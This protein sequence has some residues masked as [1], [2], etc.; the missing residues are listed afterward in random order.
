MNIPMSSYFEIS[1][2][3]IAGL[4]MGIILYHLRA[5][6]WKEEIRELNEQIEKTKSIETKI[7]NHRQF[8]KLTHQRK[9]RQTNHIQ[10]Q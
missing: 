5:R 4:A 6:T 9:K 1:L 7:K 3:L 2:Y 10:H 8:P